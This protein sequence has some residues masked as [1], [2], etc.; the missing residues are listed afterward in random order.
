M[1][2][3]GLCIKRTYMITKGSIFCPSKVNHRFGETYR[4][5]LQ[6]WRISEAI[7]QQVENSELLVYSSTVKLNHTVKFGRTIYKG[8]IFFLMGPSKF[9]SL[10]NWQNRVEYFLYLTDPIS[11]SGTG[12]C[13]ANVV[14]PTLQRNGIQLFLVRVPPPPPPPRH[15]FSST[16]YPQSCWR[17]IQ[18]IYSL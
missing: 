7:N 8:S 3:T 10:F 13:S 12:S 16:L 11:D 1:Q 9:P 17:I 15:N 2:L 6:G 5:H 14:I 4:L 18:L